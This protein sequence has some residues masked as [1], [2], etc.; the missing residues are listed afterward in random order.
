MEV[1][2]KHDTFCYLPSRST[3][4]NLKFS[5][6]I[7]ETSVIRTLSLCCPY[8]EHFTV[9][10][11]KSTYLGVALLLICSQSCAYWSLWSTTFLCTSR[12]ALKISMT[13]QIFVYCTFWQDH[14]ES[15]VGLTNQVNNITEIHEL[16][17][18]LSYFIVLPADCWLSQVKL[19]ARTMLNPW[20]E[21]SV[22]EGLASLLP[23]H[24]WAGHV[25]PQDSQAI[26]DCI[27]SKGFTWWTQNQPGCGSA[28]QD[29]LSSFTVYSSDKRIECRWWNFLSPIS[30]DF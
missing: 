9:Q 19:V 26:N 22:L 1:Q 12:M 8:Y 13:K 2:I 24:F 27:G 15:R 16:L 10:P 30:K 14:T 5:N 7:S 20:F 25:S 18:A 3:S 23:S 6:N 17:N 11:A 29:T 4:S 21:Q 28:W